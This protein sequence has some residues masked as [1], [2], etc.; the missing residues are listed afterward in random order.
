MLSFGYDMGITSL[1]ELLLSLVILYI[2]LGSSKYTQHIF[3]YSKLEL[4]ILCS[5]ILIGIL[6][7]SFIIFDLLSEYQINNYVLSLL[8]LALCFLVVFFHLCICNKL[9]KNKGYKDII[10]HFK[11]GS[12]ISGS[13]YASPMFP[14]YLSKAMYLENVHEVDKNNHH[15][16]KRI[17]NVDRVWINSGEIRDILF[18][19]PGILARTTTNKTAAQPA[20]KTKAKPKTSKKPARSRQRGRTARSQRGANS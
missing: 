6:Y 5:I 18:L 4:F 15:P 12:G 17:P 10:V 19:Q 11:D 16:M 2:F 3:R 1:S 8:S 20:T 13:Y 7:L 14:I 9:S